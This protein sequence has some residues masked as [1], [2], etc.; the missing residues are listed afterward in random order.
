MSDTTDAQQPPLPRW[1]REL[2]RLLPIRSQFVFAGNIRDSFLLPGDNSLSVMPLVSGLWSTL[3]GIGYECMVVYDR[4]DGI[5]VMPNTSDA[6]TRVE[7]LLGVKLTEGKLDTSYEKLRN[8]IRAV[9][10]AKGKDKS[11]APRIAFVVDY[12]SRIAVRDNELTEV[13]HEFFIACEKFSETAVPIALHGQV[14]I[15]FFNPLIWLVNK[16]EDMPSWYLIGNERVHA[17]MVERPDFDTR[18]LAA[19][20]L[21]QNFPNSSTE[22]YNNQNID[23]LFANLTDGMSLRSM[24]SI[25][26]LAKSQKIALSAFGDAVRLYKVGLPD[27]PWKKDGV[28]QKIARATE[29]LG[30]RVKGQPQAIQKTV[31]ILMRSVE[32]LTGAHSASTSSSRPRGLLFFAGPTGV[33]KTELAKTLTEMIFGD[34]QAYIRFD[35]S[36]FSAE[37]A[38]QRLIGAPPSYEGYSAGGELTNAIR[39]KP[40]SVVLFD[41]IEKAHPKILDKFLQ[42]LEDG[43]LTDGRGETV[44]FSEAVI[45]FTSNLGV[46]IRGGDGKWRK[47]PDATP[48]KKYEELSAVIKDGIENYF[49]YELNRPELLNRLGDNFVVFNFISKEIGQEI[50]LGMLGNI[51]N[52]VQTERGL[53]LTFS[54][55]AKVVLEQYCLDNL[56]YGGRGIANKLESVFINPLARALFT[57]STNDTALMVKSISQDSTTGIFTVVLSA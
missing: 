22:T 34:D 35:M 54:D 17:L 37:H 46:S 21:L 3:S 26:R 48:T 39:E 9:T 45:I 2:Q 33:G 32:G 25:T 24:V 27:N 38:D 49:N 4:I 52:R 1:A 53:K 11:P 55:D 31:D 43:R 51:C 6:F 19:K 41:E 14:G 36:E 16:L 40:F 47:N 29:T 42:I 44:Y 5:R 30:Q 56:M 18:K 8:Y 57:H 10:E 50:L 7:A 20:T 13:E 15:H 23:E 12:A 28:R